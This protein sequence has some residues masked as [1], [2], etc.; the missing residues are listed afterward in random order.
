MASQANCL[1]ECR[2]TRLARDAWR[3]RWAEVEETLKSMGRPADGISVSSALSIRSRSAFAELACMIIVGCLLVSCLAAPAQ[4]QMKSASQSIQLI[5]VKR[6]SISVSLT[7]GGPVTFD[8]NGNLTAGSSAPSWKTNWDLAPGQESTTVSVCVY[9]SGPLTGA[10]GSAVT[11]PASR[12]EAKS[13]GSGGFKPLSGTACGQ[14]NGLLVATVPI[15]KANRKDGSQIDSLV[16]RVNEA[17]MSLPPDTYTGTLN[18][19]AQVS[20]EIPSRK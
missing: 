3:A 9:L 8:L 11:I 2:P 15:N 12:V 10:A 4:A 20:E 16:L 1:V 6:A 17:G 7:N 5:A 13:E 14:V 18:I 19:L